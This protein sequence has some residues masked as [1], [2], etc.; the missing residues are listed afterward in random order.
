MRVL[1]EKS[2]IR[3][4]KEMRVCANILL[5]Y[6]R[7]TEDALGLAGDEGRSKATKSREELHNRRYHSRVSEWGNPG[8]GNRA[9]LVVNK[10]VIRGRTQGIETS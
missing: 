10:I 7:H 3:L 4:R 8:S 5:S 6:L 9:D 2:A 1:D